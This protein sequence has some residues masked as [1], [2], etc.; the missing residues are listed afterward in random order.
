MGVL[1]PRIRIQTPQSIIR[2]WLNAVYVSL[3][4]S[5]KYQGRLLARCDSC[6]WNTY[7]TDGGWGMVSGM[8]VD[9]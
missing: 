1:T 9:G 2:D 7:C 8:N 6:A 3:K 4:I 5:I